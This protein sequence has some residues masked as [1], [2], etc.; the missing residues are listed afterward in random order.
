[1]KEMTISVCK[2]AAREFS[3]LPKHAQKAFITYVKETLMKG[4]PSGLDTE[5]FQSV[6][7]SV[8]EVKVPGRPAGRMFYTK[9][10]TGHIE[11]LAYAKKSRNGQDPKIKSTVE[12]R[13]KDFRR[14]IGT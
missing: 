2:P 1:M 8:V 6:H 3:K 9:L 4:E 12:T 5:R 7:S 10:V 13:F 11:I 14:S